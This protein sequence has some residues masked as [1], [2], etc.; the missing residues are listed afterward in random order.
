MPQCINFKVW[1]S[2]HSIENQKSKTIGGG[3]DKTRTETV[4]AWVDE[5]SWIELFYLLFSACYTS[6]KICGLRAVINDKRPKWIK[7]L[8]HKSNA[9]SNFIK[10][11]IKWKIVHGIVFSLDSSN[12]K[13]QLFNF[14]ELSF[15]YV[16]QQ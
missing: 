16:L 10:L 1:Q 2:F 8:Q 14:I 12:E 7:T 4:W 3:I 13:L 5:T 15:K 11:A 9:N 6:F